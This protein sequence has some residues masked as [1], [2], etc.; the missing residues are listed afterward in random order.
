MKSNW[1]KRCGW[2]LIFALCFSLVASPAWAD[3][4]ATGNGLAAANEEEALANQERVEGDVGEDPSPNPEPLPE[5]FSG[6]MTLEY[7]M[8]TAL[9]N[10]SDVLE[11]ANNLEKAK[12]DKEEIDKEAQDFYEAVGE[13]TPGKI[14]QT[15]SYYQM[16]VYTP[17]MYEKQLEMAEESYDLAIA[18]CNLSVISQ[19]YTIASYGKTESYAVKAYQNAVNSYR[20]AEASYAQGMIARVDLMIAELQM[21]T[22]YQTALSAKAN[23]KNAKRSLLA[24]LGLDPD[25][26]FSLGTQMSYAPLGEI[27]AAAAVEQLIAFSPAVAIAKTTFDIAGI[28]YDCDSRYYL[29]YSYTAQVALATYK[30]AENEYNKSLLDARANAYNMIETLQDAEKQYNTALASLDSVEEGYRIA[31]LQYQ[32]GLITYNDV[33]AAEAEIYSTE[34][35]INQALMQYSIYKTA[36]DNNLI[37]SQ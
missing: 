24:Y 16:L 27:D 29:D 18:S 8:N 35:Q 37:V 21:E 11:A 22:A 28:Q 12:M 33:L 2:L 10:N 9:T 6:V 26:S 15:E 30:N 4:Y 23:T 25:I 17:S 14:E 20:T 7:A 36:L 1:K 19:Y 3:E 5:P 13:P 32:Y 34:A 31:K